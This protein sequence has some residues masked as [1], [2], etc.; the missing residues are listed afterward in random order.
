MTR[1]S[2]RWRGR[3]GGPGEERGTAA[4]GGGRRSWAGDKYTN[5]DRN[6]NPDPARGEREKM[7]EEGEGMEGSRG[8]G[9][10][11]AVKTTYKVVPQAKHWEKLCIDETYEF[12]SNPS[13][14]YIEVIFGHYTYPV[15]LLLMILTV[16]NLYVMMTTYEVPWQI[17]YTFIYLIILPGINFRIENFQLS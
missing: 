16:Y 1:P 6:R 8:K 15:T 12:N 13:L 10:R 3:E 14:P 2:G 9:K 17:K 11:K 7:T 4:G 5:V